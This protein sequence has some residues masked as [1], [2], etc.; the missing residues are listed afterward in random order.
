MEGGF[1]MQENLFVCQID[2]RSCEVYVWSHCPTH[3]GA[4]ATEDEGGRIGPDIHLKKSRY[5][6]MAEASERAIE[7]FRNRA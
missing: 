7:V 1:Y 4:N 6:T 3:W 5:R 2:Y